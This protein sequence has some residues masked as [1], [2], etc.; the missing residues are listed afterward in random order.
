M[1]VS[2]HPVNAW[3]LCKVFRRAL[4]V[5]TSDKDACGGIRAMNFAHSITRLRISRGGYGAGI[6]HHHVRG[7]VLIE[8]GPSGAAQSA[9]HRRRVCFG[10]ATAEIFQGKGS[11]ENA[12]TPHREGAG[13]RL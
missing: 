6:E 5:T 7:S 8:H 1:G 9:T 4:R 13:K 12:Q 2:H 3:K 10:S 11:H